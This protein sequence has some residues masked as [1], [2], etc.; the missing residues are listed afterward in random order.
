ML[1]R[2][3]RFLV[4]TTLYE[5]FGFVIFISLIA[6]AIC[7][8]LLPYTYYEQNPEKVLI[9]FSREHIFGTDELG[10]DLFA[11]ISYGIG[12]SLRVAFLAT[13][14]ATLLGTTI[15]IISGWFGGSVDIIIMRAIDFFIS[16]PEI[17]L[18]VIVSFVLGRGELS[19]ATAIGIVSWIS[20]ARVVRSEVLK[21]K[22][23]EFIDSAIILGN[24][25]W[26][27][28]T[29]HILPNIFPVV[30]TM[31]VLRIP[32]SILTES[33]LSF[34]GLGLRPPASSLGV[35]AEEGFRAISLFPRLTIIPSLFIVLLV[36]SS[37]VIGEYISS[38]HKR[39]S[40]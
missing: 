2:F 27:V 22:S 26:R 5:K 12:V 37:N 36:W 1:A 28:M 11:R 7:Y 18:I 4:S 32:V 3:L 33:G 23:M 16:I 31:L 9:S 38:R 29:K 25:S 19:I 8:P 30:I 10:R 17:I 39:A 35:L 34:V 40:F 21:I 24:P 13:L 20:V 15:G 6:I 14:T